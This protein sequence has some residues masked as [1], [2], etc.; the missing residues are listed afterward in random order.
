MALPWPVDFT[1]R[2][3]HTGC[4]GWGVDGRIVG[5]KTPKE[6]LKEAAISLS[7]YA[8]LR[9]AK[10]WW[11]GDE[12]ITRS[13]EFYRQFLGPDD[14][15][16][17]IGP[18]SGR[19]PKRFWRLVPTLFHLSHSIDA[20]ASSPRGIAAHEKTQAL[21]V[22]NDVYFTTHAPEIIE[23]TA[24][25]AVPAIYPWREFVDAGGLMSYGSNLTESI[26]HSPVYAAEV[27]KGKRPADLPVEQPTKFEL[28]INL[29][30][31]KILGV[32]GPANLLVAADEVIE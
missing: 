17:D 3:D 29:K 15:C 26:R 31:A 13:T 10:K 21:I 9:R 25:Y 27:L 7:L 5:W 32:T 20:F 30:T 14:I 4:A 22:A 18:M 24:R 1:A 11:A 28:I 19:K 23:L 8:P 12:R 6:A 16:F 2:S